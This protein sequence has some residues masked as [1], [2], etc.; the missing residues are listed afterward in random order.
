MRRGYKGLASAVVI[1][2]TPMT[3]AI[4]QH[5]MGPAPAANPG[6]WITADDY[7]PDAIRNNR[8]GRVVAK[9]GINANGQVV[10]C[11]VLISSG[12]TSLDNKT[13]EIAIARG[14]FNPATDAK[15]DKISSTYLLPVNWQIPDHPAGVVDLS[16]GPKTAAMEVETVIGEDGSLVSCKTI[17]HSEAATPDPCA[18]A[19]I[20]S[21]THT[22]YRLNGQPVRTTVRQRVSST[23]TATPAP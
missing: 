10:S 2:S 22:N 8:T 12:T 17:V 9:V 4:G 5:S 14:T 1:A 23:V 20:G 7:P 16:K 13:C 19:V 21:P 11:I 15:G 6:S 3:A 18:M